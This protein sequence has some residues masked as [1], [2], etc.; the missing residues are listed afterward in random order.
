MNRII[1]LLLTLLI[2]L[3]SGV[4]LAQRSQALCQGDADGRIDGQNCVEMNFRMW[5]GL[6]TQGLEEDAIIGIG[7]ADVT[8]THAQ[9]SDLETTRVQLVP[10]P[11]AG[12]Y[13]FIDWAVIIKTD[14]DGVPADT[15]SV[16]IGIAVAP[17]AGGLLTESPSILQ[18]AGGFASNL[19]VDGETYVR[20]LVPTSF[21]GR[22]STANTPIVI[23]AIGD[24]ASWNAM[25]A[26]LDN[27][28][29]LRIVV[30][31]RIIDTTDSF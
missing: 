1:S 25:V 20:R 11:G 10:A 29:T 13:L 9:L 4:A 26:E 3:V 15:A 5:S 27:T 7:S 24:A 16:W 30:R 8:V 19:F 17:P 18:V 6:N 2:L 21:V 31:Y 28:V 23:G 12:K 22:D 14:D